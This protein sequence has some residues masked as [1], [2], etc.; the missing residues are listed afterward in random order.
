MM[1]VKPLFGAVM[2]LVLAT[3]AIAQSDYV[4]VA[5]ARGTF[6][7]VKE[8]LVRA[9]EDR[10]LVVNNTAHVGLMLDRTGRDLGSNG[11]IYREAEVIEF[12]SAKISRAMMEQDPQSIVLCPYGISVYTLRSQTDAVYLAYRRFPAVP[13]VKAAAD[14]V[15]AIVNDA[16]GQ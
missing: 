14:L 11:Q 6:A 3:V 8:S 5:K 13:G 10:G 1:K 2:F 12:C 16:L 9:I 4:H 7:E 15:E